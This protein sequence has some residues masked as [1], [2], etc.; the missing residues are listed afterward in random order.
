MMILKPITYFL[1]NSKT[2]YLYNI[3]K[4]QH[5]IQIEPIYCIFNYDKKYDIFRYGSKDRRKVKRMIYFKDTI[6][7]HHIIPKEFNKH[8]LIK[9]LNYDISCSKNIY[10]LPKPICSHFLNNKDLIYHQSHPKYNTYVGSC[11]NELYKIQ[12][13]DEKKYQ[14]VLFLYYLKNGFEKNEDY[15]K[16]KMC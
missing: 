14:F 4:S 7:D 9:E 8:A 15:I 2:S 12:C 10:I 11:L 3:I 1:L 16:K 6:E 13:I 5:L